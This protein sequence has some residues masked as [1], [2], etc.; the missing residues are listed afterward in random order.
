MVHVTP[1]HLPHPTLSPRKR[2]FWVWGEAEANVCGGNVQG[3][4]IGSGLVAAWEETQG[5]TGN[6]LEKQTKV[7]NLGSF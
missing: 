6:I 4:H 2:T 1:P 3:G 5:I 7:V